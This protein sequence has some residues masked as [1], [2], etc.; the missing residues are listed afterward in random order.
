MNSEKEWRERV[1]IQLEGKYCKGSRSRSR[2]R[3]GGCVSR[4]A[5]EAFIRGVWLLPRSRRGKVANQAERSGKVSEVVE[6]S[7][8]CN[9]YHKVGKK[10]GIRK[11]M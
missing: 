11:M 2:D 4:G 5:G 3:W 10:T 1:F 8:V 6:K 7:E 9:G